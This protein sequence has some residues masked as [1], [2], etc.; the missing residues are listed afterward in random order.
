MS[1]YSFSGSRIALSYLFVI[2]CGVDHG[3]WQK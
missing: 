2:A 1:S 3:L